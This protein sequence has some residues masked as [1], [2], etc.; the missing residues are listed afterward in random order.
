MFVSSGFRFVDVD[1]V[2]VAFEPVEAVAPQ[3][4]IRREPI[5]NLAQLLRAQPID[6]PLR[7]DARRDQPGFAQHAQ[8]LRHRGLT[9]V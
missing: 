4:P 9:Y 7:I 2:E 5:I 3:F 6:S 8:V 1:L